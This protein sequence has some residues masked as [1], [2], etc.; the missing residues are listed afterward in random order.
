MSPLSLGCNTLRAANV[1]GRQWVP[2]VTLG[3]SCDVKPQVNGGS[4]ERMADNVITGLRIVGM[5]LYAARAAL[6]AQTEIARN[7][8]R[9]AAAAGVSERRIAA[10]LGVARCWTVRRWLGKA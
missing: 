4:L 5:D 1:V 2:T 9:V 6:A 8:A 7:A 3:D 10:E